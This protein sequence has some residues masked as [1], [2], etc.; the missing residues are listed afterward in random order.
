MSRKQGRL[1]LWIVVIGIIASVVVTVTPSTKSWLSSLITGGITFLL[2]M[3][4]YIKEIHDLRGVKHYYERWS[5][6]SSDAER[7]WQQGESCDWSNTLDQEI[8]RLEEREKRNQATEYSLQNDKL[9]KKCQAD[10]NTH[11]FVTGGNNV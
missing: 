9:V 1:A 3:G 7:V 10:I 8:A 6:F 11:A 4:S 5:E 2:A